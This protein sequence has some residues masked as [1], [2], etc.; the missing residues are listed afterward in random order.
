MGMERNMA[1]DERTGN[2]EYIGPQLHLGFIYWG[3]SP[4][5]GE[6]STIGIQSWNWERVPAEATGKCL[7][8]SP[9]LFER[10]SP[11]WPRAFLLG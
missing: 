11:R 1:G 10:T 2:S 5:S 3:V 9:Y 6:M 4:G 8:G 7:G